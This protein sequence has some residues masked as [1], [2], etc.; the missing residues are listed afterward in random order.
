MRWAGYGDGVVVG[1]GVGD[2]VGPGVAPGLS[3]SG[4]EGME[5]FLG[6]GRMVEP[7]EGTQ[8]LGSREETL[9]WE[10]RLKLGGGQSS[11]EIEGLL[12]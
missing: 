10:L 8:G 11:P 2:R 12:R 3:E 7:E 5:H 6:E 4:T 1:W 9:G